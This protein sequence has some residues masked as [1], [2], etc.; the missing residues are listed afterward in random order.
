VRAFACGD[1]SPILTD[2]VFSNLVLLIHY[3]LLNAE[4]RARRLAEASLRD[5]SGRLLKMQDDERRR[6]ARELHDSA[7]QILAALSM[8]LTPLTT[9]TSTPGL[10]SVKVIEESLGLVSEL[11]MEV[12][13]ISLLLHPR[14]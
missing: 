9:E 13:T 4:S 5:L 11:T 6:I 2:P 1:T 7:G 10:H 14:C 3:R 12:R 8:K